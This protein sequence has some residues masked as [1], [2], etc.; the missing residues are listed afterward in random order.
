MSKSTCTD[1]KEKKE[2]EYLLI[3]ITQGKQEKKKRRNCFY[4]QLR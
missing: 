1:A 4:L 3:S 2:K